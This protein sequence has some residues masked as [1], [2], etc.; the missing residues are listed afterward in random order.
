MILMSLC[1]KFIRV[2]VYQ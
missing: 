2:Y 1:Y